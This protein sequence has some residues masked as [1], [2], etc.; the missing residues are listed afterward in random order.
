MCIWMAYVSIKALGENC[1]GGRDT[2]YLEALDWSIR[3]MET[4]IIRNSDITA[5]QVT[6]GRAHFVRQILEGISADRESV[7]APGLG[8]GY[9]A[10]D[11]FPTRQEIEADMRGL[12]S[13]DRPPVWNPCL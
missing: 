6:Q 5:D 8:S 3:E 7:C 2:A 1:Y 11:K 10:P 13:I 4:F 12:L 9:P